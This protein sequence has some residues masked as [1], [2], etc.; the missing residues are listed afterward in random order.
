[1]KYEKKA[2]ELIN[3]FQ[4]NVG[5]FNEEAIK[6]ALILVDEILDL[7]YVPNEKSSYN[8]Y[9]YYSNVKIELLKIKRNGIRA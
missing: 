5:M 3:K 7:G 8:V 9:S 4:N 6:S 2:I 1:M